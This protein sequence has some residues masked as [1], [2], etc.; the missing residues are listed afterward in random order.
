MSSYQHN[1]TCI[2]IRKV[3]EFMQK[4]LFEIRRFFKAVIMMQLTRPLFMEFIR[5]E[6]LLV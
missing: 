6:R 2:P 5:S 3:N 1:I 4:I